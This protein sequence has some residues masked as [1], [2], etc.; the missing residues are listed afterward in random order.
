MPTIDM[1]LADLRQ[2]NGI[3][4][5]PADFDEFWD[6]SLSELAAI[7]PKPEFVPHDYKSKIAD[8]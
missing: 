1:P 4:P 3:N 5:R 2:Y 7:D 6:K 8:L